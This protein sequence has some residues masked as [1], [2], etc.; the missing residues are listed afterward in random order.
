MKCR[1]RLVAQACITYSVHCA[2]V[3]FVLARGCVVKFHLVELEFVLVLAPAGAAIDTH[4]FV[5]YFRY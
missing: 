2:T 3:D 4:V 1:E 5:S